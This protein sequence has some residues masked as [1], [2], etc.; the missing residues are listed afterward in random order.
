MTRAFITGVTGCVGSNLAAALLQKGIDVVGLCQPGAPDLAIQGLK[1]TRVEGDIRNPAE[2]Q[3]LLKEIDWV[4][5]VAAIADDWR[6]PAEK[7][8]QTNVAGTQNMLSAALHAGVKRF[9]LTSSAAALGVPKIKGALLDEKSP[10]NLKPKDWVYAHSKVLAE[11][12]LQQAVRQG[13]PALSVL[14]TAILGP[15][16]MNF[17]SGQLIARAWKG[18]L[19]PFPHGGVNFI[20]VRD[21]AQAQ[22]EAA[23]HGTVGER[24]LLGGHNLSHLHILGAIGDV[25]NVPIAYWNVPE[26][27]L[28]VMA[29]TMG[30]LRKVGLPVPIDRQRI[31][32]SRLYMYYDNHKAV[33]ALGL[34][35]RSFDETVADTFNWYCANGYLKR[36][37]PPVRLANVQA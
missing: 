5:H 2:M 1:I 15:A 22:I 36:R 20:D 17:I 31:R 11:R 7:I 26:A 28:P 29:E 30:L 23:L 25:L 12:A 9:V 33:E 37:T 16:D 6:Y 8:Y 35:P 14:P 13:L 27:V 3:T 18:E 10:F 21:V 4:F 34:R 24:Y 19:F 32:M